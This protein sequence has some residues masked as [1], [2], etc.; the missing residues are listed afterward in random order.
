[1]RVTHITRGQAGIQANT[2]AELD[3]AVTLLI[4]AGYTVTDVEDDPT[5]PWHVATVHYTGG[6]QQIAAIKQI[7]NP[8]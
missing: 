4:A 3:E 5:E 7:V 2:S 6:P 8:A 1:M